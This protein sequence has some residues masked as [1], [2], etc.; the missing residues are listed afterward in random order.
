MGKITTLLR[1]P[2]LLGLLAIMRD[3]QATVRSHF[4]YAAVESG[5][6]MALD[7]PRSKEELIERLNVKRPEILDAL[8]EIGLAVGELG[9]NNDRYRLKGRRARALIADGGDALAALIQANST[10]YNAIYL[11]AT[12]RLRGGENGDYLPQIGDIVARFSQAVAPFEQEFINSIVAK[13]TPLRVLDVGCGAGEHLRYVAEANPQATG[14][15]I[16][17]DEVVVELAQQNAAVWDGENRFEVISGDIRQPPAAL[18]G[19]Y[20]LIL[21]FNNVY[22]FTISSPV[23]F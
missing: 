19:P 12:E 18:R 3:W 17:F 9:L 5:L 16:D 10:Y 4:L 20:D 2:N 15:G 13:N 11:E 7:Q 8:L 14:L 1:L 6:L 22:Y 21:M 23:S